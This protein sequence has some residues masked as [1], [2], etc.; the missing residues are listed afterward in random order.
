VKPAPAV[1]ETPPPPPEPVARPPVEPAPPEPAPAAI[2]DA[3]RQRLEQAQRL[4]RNGKAKE[5]EGVLEELVSEAPGLAEAQ[6]LL[7]N[8]RL[9]QG[10]V[11]EAL[12]AAKQAVAADPTLADAYLALGV[13]AQELGDVVTA[14]GAYE[15]Y[16]ELAPRARYASTVRAQLRNLQRKL[17]AP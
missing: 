16:L 5:A 17:P 10:K 2:S 6:A 4:Y 8:A 3:Q 7:A 1:G 12:P 15:R 11:A 9:D 13:I 14:V